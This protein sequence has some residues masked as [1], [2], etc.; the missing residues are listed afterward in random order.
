MYL[1]SRNKLRTAVLVGLALCLAGTTASRAQQQAVAQV[2][3]V[4]WTPAFEQTNPGTMVLTNRPSEAGIILPIDK[5]E[6]AKKPGPKGNEQ[7]TVYLVGGPRLEVDRGAYT[8]PNPKMREKF[9]LQ[10][11]IWPPNNTTMT[12]AHWHRELRTEA[13]VFGD[14]Y[15]HGSGPVVD[16]KRR[17]RQYQ[18]DFLV[19][20]AGGHHFGWTDPNT[21][22]NTVFFIFGS[23]PE[24]DRPIGSEVP[25]E[26]HNSFYPKDTIQWKPGQG[27]GPMTFNMVGDATKAGYYN[28]INKWRPGNALNARTYSN[29]RYGMVVSG[30]IYIGWGDKLDPKKGHLMTQ[31]TFFSQPAGMSVFMYVPAGEQE[32]AVVIMYG[33]GPSQFKTVESTA[34]TSER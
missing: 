13:F 11:R 4:G 12:E 14:A 3:P 19:E 27:T 17:T 32:D 1:S 29:D 7:H 5:V 20:E 30:R 16:Q 8:I 22:E 31:G 33:K 18:G 24:V 10:W 34:T 15:W 2:W 6:F 25:A 21:H 28:E 26:K 9:Y 23:E